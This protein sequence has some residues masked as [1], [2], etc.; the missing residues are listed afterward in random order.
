[1]WGSPTD[2]SGDPSPLTE[3][4]NFSGRNPKKIRKKSMFTC[5]GS[6]TDGSGD[7][8][9][10]TE[11]QNF[12]GRNPKKIRKK[13]MFTCGGSSTDGSGD[14]SPLTEIQNFSGRNP[15]IL[16]GNPQKKSGRNPCLHVG[17]ALLMGQGIRLL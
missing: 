5:G 11:I 3:I 15:E 17:G 1:M 7:P 12:S 8:S 13:S 14:P 16:R 9:P 10:L 6:S 4:Q 2:G